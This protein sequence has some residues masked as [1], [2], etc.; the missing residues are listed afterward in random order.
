MHAFVVPRALYIESQLKVRIEGGT[1]WPLVP[2]EFVAEDTAQAEMSEAV[3]LDGTQ[4]HL[5][6]L[7]DLL[8]MI[9]IIYHVSHPPFGGHS[10]KVGS[11]V[12]VRR[13]GNVIRIA[14][15]AVTGGSG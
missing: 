5:P 7:Y 12:D 15:G 10:V 14:Q 6:Y 1:T 9:Y 11:R 13:C 8:Q 3:L 2:T 4:A